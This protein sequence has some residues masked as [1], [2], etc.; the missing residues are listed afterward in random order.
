MPLV[1]LALW[2]CGAPGGA[3]EAEAG[4]TP[5]ELRLLATRR[6]PTTEPDAVISAYDALKPGLREQRIRL[7]SMDRER[8]ADARCARGASRPEED[9][10]LEDLKRGVELGGC[11]AT[12]RQRLRQ[13]LAQRGLPESYVRGLKSSDTDEP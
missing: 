5:W 3:D 1:M 9:A 7:D 11:D 12:Q 10:A 2:G 4:P 13:L 6:I 8:V